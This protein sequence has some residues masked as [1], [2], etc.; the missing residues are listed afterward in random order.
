MRWRLGGLWGFATP[1]LAYAWAAFPRYSIDHKNLHRKATLRGY[2]TQ[3]RRGGVLTSPNSIVTKLP[4]GL[5]QA[6]ESGDCVLFLGAGVGAHYARSDG[7]SAPDGKGLV[8]ELIQH[9]K[10]D[11][12]PSTDLPRAS[13]LVEIRNGRADL[14]SFLKKCLQNLEPDEHIRWLTTFR[15]R[16][17]YTTNYDMGLE[18]AYQLN[19]HPLQTPIPISVTANLVYSDTYVNVPIFHLHGTPY[20]PCPSP[21]VITQSDYTKYQDHRKMVWD[22][23]KNDFATSVVLYIGYSGRDH[24]WQLIVEEVAREFSPAKPPTTYRLDPYADPIDAEIHKETRRVETLV[25]SLPAFREL[26]DHEIGEYRPQSD[27]ANK[28]KNKI[29]HHLREDFDKN[30]AAMLRLLDSWLYVNGETTTLE[31]NT[32]QFLLGSKSNWSLIAQGHRFVR[33]V[34]EELWLWA[35]DF[36]TDV[37]AKSTAL[38]LTG[39]AGYGIT[40]ILMALALKLV[41]AIKGPVFFLRE[42]AEVNEGDIAYAATLFPEV[43]CY[44]VVDQAR[45]HAANIQT[46]LSQQRK[47]TSNCLFILGERRNEWLS[48]NTSLTGRVFDIEPLSDGE[49]NLL[50]DFLSAEGALGDLKELE[51]SFQFSIIKNKH[52]QQ[53]LVAMREATAGD[54]VGFDAIIESEFQGVDPGK[55]ES[56]ARQ[57][58][59]LV[60]CFYQHGIL[61]RDRV[62]ESVIDVELQN[63]YQQIGSS[64]EGMI[65]YS[66]TKI[67]NGE[68]AARARH[69]IIAE[70]V[71]KK[72]GSQDLKEHTL[73]KAIENL[74]FTYRLDKIAFDLFIRSDEI[75]DT[76]RTLEGKTKFFETAARKDPENVFVLQHFARMLL[77]EDKLMLALNEINTAITKDR[78][79]TIR[80]L[81]HTRG[82]IL[83]EL[84]RTE[85]NADVARNWLL[86]S[87]H[88]FQY[89]MTAKESDSYGHSG[90]AA[91]YLSWARRPKASVDEATEYLQKAQGIVFDGLKVVRERTSLL[92]TSAEIQKE[93]GNKPA[94][95]AKLREAVATDSASAVGRYLLGRAYREQGQPLNAME[96]L[97]PIIR[98]DFK[99]VR[100]YLEYT[101]SMLDAGEPIKKCAATLSQ[102]KLDGEV[103][104]QFVGLYGGLLHMEGKYTEAKAV[105]DRAKQQR[106]PYDEGVRRQYR[107]IDPADP[108][109]RR[110]FEGIIQ[111][112][113]PN[114]VFIQPE[115][116]PAVF[117]KSTEVAGKPLIRS[118]A[119]TFELSFSA[120]GPLAENLQVP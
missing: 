34:E 71:W 65:E 27:T 30:P 46:A 17:I 60:C 86:Q 39:P 40:T 81:R 19:S 73:Q 91:L 116:G 23:L 100:A 96:V 47:T 82:L 117:S 1:N 94:Q 44:F 87:E 105:W 29:P 38:L 16:A 36:I 120:R 8:E 72:C 35:L 31:P 33:D 6:L 110:R 67:G 9:F 99:H 18:R 63:L 50:L 7:K 93:L 51:R 32:K 66:E 53:L 97:E 106:F 90:L 76:F 107:P 52:E 41:D 24:N 37:K 69:R 83:A 111:G 102:C 42:G 78:T 22:R 103:E 58:Y 101:R 48:A 114:F 80:S 56:L 28:Y 21:M 84:A 79:R 112:V 115:D 85:L 75:V 113:K 118:Q 57:L 55:S 15:W 104:P 54:G 13:S 77:R 5:R 20:N 64:L 119:V 61:I 10:L 45:E 12:P 95:L 4:L 88:E 70:I 3:R 25:L 89:C 108:G 62:C 2:G 109:R 49:I 74:N 43:P 68:Y 98:S 59:L 92:I 26:V 11:I 14:D